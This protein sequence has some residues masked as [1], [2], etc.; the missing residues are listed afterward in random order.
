MKD[1]KKILKYIFNSF[2]D[3]IL[4]KVKSINEFVKEDPDYSFFYNN[5][6]T[7]NLVLIE[8]KGIKLIGKPQNYYLKDKVRVNAC[9]FTDNYSQK[10]IILNN[11]NVK[12]VLGDIRLFVHKH[13][14][15]LL[16]IAKELKTI[17]ILTLIN[18]FMSAQENNVPLEKK[19]LKI[20]NRNYKYKLNVIH[21][22]F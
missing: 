18:I 7:N 1:L 4:G 22:T 16:T 6:D 19:N 21:N 12:E 13:Q 9:Y 3:F 15:E 11:D 10:P 17:S 2:P 20:L 14:E 5:L 8:H